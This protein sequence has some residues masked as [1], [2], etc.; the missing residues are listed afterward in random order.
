MS[1]PRSRTVPL[2]AYYHDGKALALYRRGWQGRS[3]N[4]WKKKKRKMMKNKKKR[5]R[6]KKI[7]EEQKRRGTRRQ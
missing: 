1:L 3:R 6:R 4:R 2:I 7:E 5:K